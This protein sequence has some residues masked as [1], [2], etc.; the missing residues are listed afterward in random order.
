[1]GQAAAGV[2]DPTEVARLCAEGEEAADFLRTYVVQA[3][4][5]ERG[6][7]GAPARRAWVSLNASTGQP[8]GALGCGWASPSSIRGQSQKGRL[9]CRPAL[10]RLRQGALVCVYDGRPGGCCGPRSSGGCS[11]A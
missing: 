11:D 10:L 7:Y 5:N 9:S 3:R 4:L 8:G 6:N 2:A 1:M